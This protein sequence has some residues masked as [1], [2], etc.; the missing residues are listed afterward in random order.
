MSVMTMSHRCVRFAYEASRRRSTCQQALPVERP[1]SPMARLRAA[2]GASAMLTLLAVGALAPAEAQDSAPAASDLQAASQNPI[3]KLISVPFQNNLYT[4]VGPNDDLQYFL[5]IQPVVPVSFGDRWN[6]IIRPIVP[7]IA[8]PVLFPGGD[9]EAGLGNIALQT[10]MSPDAPI[11]SGIGDITWG[12][13][14]VLSFPTHSDRTLG[15]R[16]YTA[17]PAVVAFVLKEPFTYGFLAFNQWSIAGP[18]GEPEVNQLT[19]QPFVNYNL[20]DGWSIGTSPVISVDWTESEDNVTLPL[21]GGVSKLLRVGKQP[22]KLAAN[23][24][25]NVLRPNEGAEWQFQFQAQLLFPK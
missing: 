25:Y 16:D 9:S 15:S 4:G 22:V 23:A 12:V 1:R 14:S 20:P 21:G 17:G 18:S 3:A 24:Y 13:G 5:N 6:L 8:N 7:I 11:Q 2:I 10:F 19:F